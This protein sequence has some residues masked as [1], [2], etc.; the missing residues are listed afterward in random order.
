MF[1]CRLDDCR[2]QIDALAIGDGEEGRESRLISLSL[3]ITAYTVRR[4]D[5]GLR[6]VDTLSFVSSTSYLDD[7]VFLCG[8][9]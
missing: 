9:G 3:S 8:I 2:P 5:L 1:S 7:L 4:R 6:R